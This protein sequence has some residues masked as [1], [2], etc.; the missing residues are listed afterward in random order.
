MSIYVEFERK[1]RSSDFADNDLNAIWAEFELAIKYFED[2]DFRFRLKNSK[3]YVF[4]LETIATHSEITYEKL[5]LLLQY[6]DKVKDLFFDK[7]FWNR[8]LGRIYKRMMEVNGWNRETII[9]Q[10]FKVEVETG[11]VIV[12]TRENTEIEDLSDESLNLTPNLIFLAVGGDG[13]TPVEIEMINLPKPILAVKDYK[14]EIISQSEFK[15]FVVTKELII[16]DGA[17]PNPK[18]VLLIEV[19]EY[20]VCAYQFE[21][22]VKVVVSKV[23]T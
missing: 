4:V 5:E 2:A 23:A 1:I 21:T 7:F 6:L 14:K 8:A 3:S 10:K 19:G 15:S 18:N 12:T 13:R 17:D 16:F 20:I 9:S 22:K 11:L